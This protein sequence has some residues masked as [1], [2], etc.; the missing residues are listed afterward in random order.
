MSTYGIKK[1]I[2]SINQLMEEKGKKS[3][4]SGEKEKKKEKRRGGKWLLAVAWLPNKHV[5]TIMVFSQRVLDL[6]SKEHRF[7][8]ISDTYL[9]RDI[10][11]WAFNYTNEENDHKRD[12]H[13][14][15]LWIIELL[16]IINVFM[17]KLLLLHTNP[18]KSNT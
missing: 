6:E 14:R 18:Y 1:K 15:I 10:P 16:Y 11:F 9:K 4:G 7:S 5:E 8:L 12:Y 17:H 13:S 3:K 2:Q